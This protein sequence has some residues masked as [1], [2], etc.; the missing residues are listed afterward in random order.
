MAKGNKGDTIEIFQGFTI[1]VPQNILPNLNYANIN[2][3]HNIQRGN[4][5]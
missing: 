4:V 3:F 5:N 2:K 1:N